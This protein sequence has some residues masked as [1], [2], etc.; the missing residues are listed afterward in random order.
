MRDVSATLAPPRHPRLDRGSS[1][2]STPHTTLFRH[3]GLDP[4]SAFNRV[5][6][7]RNIPCGTRAAQSSGVALSRP[8]PEVAEWLFEK[9]T[10]KRED[11]VQARVVKEANLQLEVCE[12][13][14]AR[15]ERRLEAAEQ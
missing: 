14:A 9:G 5:Q 11:V 4:G 8:A 12:A 13:D 7:P 6:D 2:F 15:F 10:L 3:P 1:F